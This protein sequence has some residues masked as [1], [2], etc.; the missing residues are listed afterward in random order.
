[1]LFKIALISALAPNRSI[2]HADSLPWKLPRDMRF[3]RRMTS[4]HAVLMG[5]KTFESLGCKPLPKRVN[6]VLSRTAVYD[7]PRVLIARDLEEA[8][9]IARA[10]SQKERLFVIGGGSVYEQTYTLADELYLTQI[11]PRNPNQ[12]HLFDEEF[13]GD[14]FFPRIRGNWDLCHLSRL[15][16]ALDTTNPKSDPNPVNYYFRFF[17]YGKRSS[18]GCTPAE[19]KQVQKA[20]QNQQEIMYPILSN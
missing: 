8:I 20:L 12:I 18:C 19:K 16:R 13:Y 4:G 15:Y 3:F 7:H 5:R 11:Q 10:H 9:D 17:K 1:M 6:I 2:G 14:T